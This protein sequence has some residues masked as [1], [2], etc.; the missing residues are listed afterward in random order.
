[1]WTLVD[2]DEVN[3]NRCFE[4]FGTGH[5]IPQSEFIGR[6]YIGTV[7]IYGGSLI[8]HIFEKIVYLE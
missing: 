6:K 5:F 8:F 4:M 1:M 2:K 7:Q 3:I